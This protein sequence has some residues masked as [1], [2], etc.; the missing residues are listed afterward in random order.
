M[1]ESPGLRPGDSPTPQ[2]RHADVVAPPL[3]VRQKSGERGP[4][5]DVRV[6][7][8]ALA[9]PDGGHVREIARDLHT[10][11][12]VGTPL[13]LP[14]GCLRQISHCSLQSISETLEIS[15]RV[16]RVERPIARTFERLHVAVHRFPLAHLLDHIMFVHEEEARAL[17]VEAKYVDH[18]TPPAGR[19]ALEALDAQLDIA[20]PRHVDEGADLLPAVA[21]SAPPVQQ[22]RLGDHG[23]QHGGGPVSAVENLLPAQPGPQRI[24]P[25]LR[26]P[27]TGPQH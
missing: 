2:L 23:A 6:A 24:T 26:W 10:A 21:V 4:P 15:H 19:P 14:P 25:P 18:E 11:P 27:G 12:V 20:A 9:V 16:A 1:G 5:D 17:A 3:Y 22:G 8:R 13:G 7:F